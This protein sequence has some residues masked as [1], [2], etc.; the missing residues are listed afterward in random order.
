MASG[1]GRLYGL[2]TAPRLRLTAMPTPRSRPSR[3]K[4]LDAEA[5]LRALHAHVGVLQA[6]LALARVTGSRKELEHVSDSELTLVATVCAHATDRMSAVL[7]R[8][9]PELA[10]HAAAVAELACQRE[11]E[12]P[13]PKPA[14]PVRLVAADGDR[15]A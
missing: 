11:F 5:N 14:S 2:A 15:G 12:Q 7:Q 4:L 3:R 6:R 1:P 10:A 13:C 9:S 8:L